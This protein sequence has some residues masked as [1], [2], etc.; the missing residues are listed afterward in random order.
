MLEIVAEESVDLFPVQVLFASSGVSFHGVFGTCL[1]F[2]LA[3]AS[4][5]LLVLDLILVWLLGIGVGTGSVFGLGFGLFF[6]CFV[7]L[8]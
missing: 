7:R 2:I 3:W 8:C 5:W 4:V 1:C 6:V